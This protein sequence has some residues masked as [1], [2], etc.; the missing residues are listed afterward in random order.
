M[1][2]QA[3]LVCAVICASVFFNTIDAQQSDT[4]TVEQPEDLNLGHAMEMIKLSTDK[5]A[6]LNMPVTI[7]I[8]DRHDNLV[9][10]ARME[11]AALGS[12]AL[13]CQKARSSALFPAPS[14]ALGAFPGIQ[15]SN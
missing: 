12:V 4:C 11:N 14:S 8:M 13:A 2:V 10:H 15:L 1:V 9:L 6:E 5:A 3:L 7:C